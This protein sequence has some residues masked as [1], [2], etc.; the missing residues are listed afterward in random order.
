MEYEAYNETGRNGMTAAERRA[1]Y[2]SGQAEKNPGGKSIAE[3]E[4]RIQALERN[5]VKAG[6]GISVNGNQVSVDDAVSTGDVEG[7]PLLVRA[8]QDIGGT[9][10]ASTITVLTQ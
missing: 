10:T 2:D 8:V 7:T 4:R 5:P 1:L 3:L 6:A 9:L